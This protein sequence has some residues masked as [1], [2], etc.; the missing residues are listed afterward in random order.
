MKPVILREPPSAAM[1]EAPLSEPLP[2][3]PVSGVVVRKSVLVDILRGYLPGLHD[4]QVTE[5]GEYFW[6]MLEGRR[7]D[8][9]PLPQN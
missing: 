2:P 6:L 4:L 5:D 1:D 7:G 8:G 9:A 3:L